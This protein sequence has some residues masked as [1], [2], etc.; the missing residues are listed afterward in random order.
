MP[1]PRSNQIPGSANDG[2]EKGI[3]RKIE[4]NIRRCII[5]KQMQAI[6]PSWRN[7]KM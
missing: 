7:G 5:D 6:K 4:R 3:R 1:D 2:D